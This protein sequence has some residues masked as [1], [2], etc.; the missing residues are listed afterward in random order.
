MVG[1]MRAALAVL[2]TVLTLAAP[3]APAMSKAGDSVRLKDLGRL[4]GWRENAVVGYGLVTGLAGT[5]DSPRNQATRQSIANLLQNFDLK[6]SADQVN[7]RNVAA[8]MVTASLPA[9]ARRGDGLDITVTSMG[10]ARS[11]L[12]GTLLLTPLKGP[13][14]RVYALAQGSVSVG[15]YRYDMNGNVVQK[16]HPTV[17]T[18]PAGASVEVQVAADVLGADRQ[19]VFVLSR[20]DYTTASRV[21]A[22]INHAV[23]EG[24]A[25]AR[26][27]ADIEIRPTAQ[28]LDDLVAFVT[29][30]ENLAVEPDRR[31]RVVINER[32]GVVVAGGDVRI[33]RVSISHGDLRVSIVTDNAVSQPIVIG[34]GGEGVRTELV[35]NSRV[36]VAESDRGQFVG[37]AHNTVAD[38]VQALSR[39]KTSTR[40]IISILNAVRAAGAL[41]ADLIIQ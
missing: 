26:T 16:N 18:V 4:G 22:A 6:L 35:S 38:L 12:G 40:D 27:A 36:D 3:S 23:G 14:G 34:R 17:G 10:D 32:T 41:H 24:T 25:R 30:V 9:F 15:G 13:D 33:S 28:Q 7:S 5:G 11:L 37:P 19:L 39:L 2:A 20:P 8:V 31:A 29:S 21:A 1:T